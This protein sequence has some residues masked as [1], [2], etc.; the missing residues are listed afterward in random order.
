MKDSIL[1]KIR[2]FVG[3]LPIGAL[4]GLLVYVANIE[5]QDLD[6]WLHLA[7]GKHIMLKGF[8]PSVDFF[9]CTIS[10]TP[11]INHE[12]LFQIIVYNIFNIFGPDGLL[13]MQIVVVGVTMGLLLLIGYSKDKQLFT[14][15]F[16]LLANRQK[17][18]L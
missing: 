1:K 18:L 8:V 14:T 15:F 11:W 4:F 2:Y 12:W 7:A 17:Q 3:L 16:L 6:L 5:V 13:K 9:S 10:G